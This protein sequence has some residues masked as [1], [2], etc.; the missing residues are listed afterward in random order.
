MRRD[1][2]IAAPPIRYILVH[3][4]I[5]KNGGTTIE[6]ILQRE[7]P[8]A[9]ATVHGP[10]AG[11]TLDARQLA[12]FLKDNQAVSA[13]SSHHLRYPKPSLR[14]IA[15]FDCCFIRH[16]LDRIRSMYAYFRRINSRDPLCRMARTRNLREFVAGLI[17][18]YPHLIHNAQVVLLGHAGLFTRPATEEDLA[19]ATQV[20]LDMAVPGLVEMFDESLLVAEYFLQPAFPGLRLEYV[21][22]NRSG[23]ADRDLIE[24]EQQWPQLWGPSINDQLVR[25][26]QLDLQLYRAAEQEVGRRLALVPNAGE[27]MAQFRSRCLHLQNAA[28]DGA[29]EPVGRPER[30]TYVPSPKFAADHFLRS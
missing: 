17:E 7:F 18:G 9:F 6:S 20:L 15:L 19:R 5:F 23:D 14:H 27:R 30:K 4:H 13:V 24:R 3:Y 26:N 28:E 25:L 29:A 10:T 8:G 22:Q 16:P 12:S 11:A 21:P 2:T 1:I